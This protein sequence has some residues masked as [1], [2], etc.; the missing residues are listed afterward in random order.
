MFETA[1]IRTMDDIA[2]LLNNEEELL[3]RV[4]E[5]YEENVEL[6]RRND[7]TLTCST[8][9]KQFWS[10]M[11]RYLPTETVQNLSDLMHKRRTKREQSLRKALKAL[12]KQD[13]VP[14]A[15]RNVVVV[16]DETIAK[17][18]PKTPR[19]KRLQKTSVVSEEGITL[20][21]K[22]VKQSLKQ[23]VS[24]PSPLMNET[25]LHTSA[26]EHEDETLQQR[27]KRRVTPHRKEA[28]CQSPEISAAMPHLD[29]VSE[30]STD[31]NDA[32]FRRIDFS[33]FS[34]KSKTFLLQ[35]E[36]MYHDYM[37]T[38]TRNVD[39]FWSRMTRQFPDANLGALRQKLSGSTKNTKTKKRNPTGDRCFRLYS[40]E[41]AKNRVVFSDAPEHGEYL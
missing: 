2:S 14:R 24:I 20:S 6:K 28:F 32:Y 13:H 9:A 4:E 7:P 31:V 15:K 17:V 26:M 30:E 27:T 22:R 16:P 29:N 40:N 5:I 21:K 36:L 39:K 11:R 33:V 34:P 12:Q 25:H 38:G 10:E 37:S 19:K 41:I 23:N 35:I 8:C 1:L 18:S 3:L